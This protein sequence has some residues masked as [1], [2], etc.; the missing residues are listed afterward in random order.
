M[1][2]S[3]DTV[4]ILAELPFFNPILE[5]E[6]HVLQTCPIYN[7]FREFNDPTTLFAD[8]KYTLEVAKMV[9]RIDCRRFPINTTRNW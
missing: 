4:K 1:I 2:K 9:T 5:D 8:Q 3:E 6:E 7:D